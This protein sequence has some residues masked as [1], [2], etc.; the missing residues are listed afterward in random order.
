V[1]RD[2]VRIIVRALDQ[3]GAKLPF[4][5]EPVEIDVTGPAHLIGPALVPLRGGSTGFWLESTGTRGAIRVT[6]KSP[7]FGFTVLTLTAD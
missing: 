6:V 4:L 7:R 3:T 2:S 1:R 5:Q